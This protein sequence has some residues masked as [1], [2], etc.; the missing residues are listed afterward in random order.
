MSPTVDRYQHIKVE[1]H[2]DVFHVRLRS[3]R[4]EESEVYELAEELI[5][6]C[7]QDGCRKLALSLGP[8]PPRCLYSVFLAKLI[9]VQRVLHEHGG[10]LRL[11]DVNPLTRTVFE[12][13]LLEQQFA[14]LPDCDAAVAQWGA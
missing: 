4:L 3:T 2:G 7:T 9:T 13:S 11:C 12:A 14:F 1:R 5:A 10:S 8:E 6:L